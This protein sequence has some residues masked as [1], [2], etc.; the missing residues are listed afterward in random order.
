MTPVAVL[1]DRALRLGFE[2]AARPA[3][4]IAACCAACARLPGVE[5]WIPSRTT[6]TVAY[7]P[8]LIDLDALVAALA[9][10]ESESVA[11]RRDPRRHVIPV[12]YGGADGPD[13]A[14]VAR[15]AGLTE[16]QV[17]ERHSAPVYT[18][19]MI[20]FTPGFPYLD[21]LDPWLATPRLATP[22]LAV[23]AGS[24]GIGGDQTG[25]YPSST[26][27]GWRLIGRTAMTLFD[28][29]SENLSVLQ[30]GD[31]VRFVPVPS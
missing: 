7:D 19:A 14:F 9:A 29:D 26:P 3:D 11:E 5:D 24:V 20:G 27:G 13:L 28:P 21:G 18:V 12:A 22:R 8:R 2:A 16:A 17:I 23:P 31:Q 15:H 10:A 25:I 6:L 1:G 30:A 4:A